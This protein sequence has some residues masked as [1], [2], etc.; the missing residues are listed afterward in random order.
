LRARAALVGGIVTHVV[1]DLD[2]ARSSGAAG[3]GLG[4]ALV[5]ADDSNMDVGGR[6]RAA[7]GLLASRLLALQLALGLLAVGGLEALVVAL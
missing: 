5:G 6:A 3:G 7:L 2:E 1:H 4:A